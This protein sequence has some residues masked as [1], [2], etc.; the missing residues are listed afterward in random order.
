VDGAELLVL[1]GAQRIL[2]ESQ[3]VVLFEAGDYTSDFGYKQQSVFDFLSTFGY[4]FFSGRFSSKPLEP[5]E[6]FTVA[7]DYFALAGNMAPALDKAAVETG[8]ADH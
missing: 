6:G 8:K 7:E 4:R 2:R 5:R 3:P 1:R